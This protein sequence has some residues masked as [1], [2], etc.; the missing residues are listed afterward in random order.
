MNYRERMKEYLKEPDE[1]SSQYGKWA[2]LNREQRDLI[3]RLLREM[4]GAD[5]VI[6]HQYFEIERLKELSKVDSQQA[7]EIIIELKQKIERLN[8]IIKHQDTRNSRQ[9]IANRKLLDRNQDLLIENL[10]LNNIIN[11]IKEWIKG[12]R[13]SYASCK[14]YEEDYIE[15]IEHLE[16]ELKGS[17]SNE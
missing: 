16:E 10:K 6:K 15:F 14:W 17:G 3:K 1:Y 9:R 5:E 13:K 11:E 2:I 8:N 4:D 12:Y 7:Q